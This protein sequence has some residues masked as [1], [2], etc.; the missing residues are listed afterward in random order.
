M[1]AAAYPRPDA[2]LFAATLTPHR[3]MAHNQLLMAAALF[4]GVCAIPAALFLA[5][6]AWP[7]V[8]FLGLDVLIIVLAF[9]ASRNAAR[10]YETV[11]LTPESLTIR[12][13]TA[14]G[15]A[16][17]FVLDPN[18]ARLAI[19]RTEDGVV[20]IVVSVRDKA[21]AIGRFLPP[22]EKE[23]FAEAFAPALRKVSMLSR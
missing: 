10:A 8:G 22:G 4:A 11:V 13:V 23:T 19:E 7:I 9:R 20:D 6:G 3:S 1:N 18:W 21:V 17:Q 14:A 12:H 2:P 5:M 15:K 16:R